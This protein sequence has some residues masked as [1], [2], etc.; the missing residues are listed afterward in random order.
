M[1]IAV[2]A[3]N[4]A[5][6][7]FV[8]AELRK[9]HVV[10]VYEHSD[11]DLFNL[12][13]INRLIDWCNLAYFEFAQ[14][15]L[16][17]V[18]RLPCMDKPVVVRGHGIPLFNPHKIDWEKVSL[19]LT[20][21]ICKQMFLDQNPKHIPEI[22]EVPVGAD[23]HLFSFSPKKEE[24][25]FKKRIVLQSSVFRPKKRVYTSIQLYSELYDEDDKW[26]LYI[27][28][29]WESG[30]MESTLKTQEQYN[31]PIRKLLETLG[32]EEIVWFTPQMPR[33]IWSEFLWDKDVIWSNS[34]LEGFHCSLAEGMLAGM[35]PVINHWWGADKFYPSWAIYKTW[36]DMK[37]ALLTW[38]DL[39]P[40]EKYQKA[41]ESREEI[42]KRGYDV[43]NIAIKIR[44]GI[45]R[46]KKRK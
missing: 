39:D 44:Q 23:T 35:Y 11:N 17:V 27:V 14:Y 29:N 15:P 40:E 24:R 18:T 6:Y 25:Q 38:A 41:K 33:K 22:V 26:E 8:D 13:Q 21:P 43:R 45:E 16:D 9:H 3:L 20:S 34:N 19:M 10:R 46:V 30:F 4:N 37:K 1:K 42:I 31:W 28:G 36:R 5:F 32:L 12:I 2:F 7:A